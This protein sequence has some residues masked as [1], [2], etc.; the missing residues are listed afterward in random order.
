MF[1]GWWQPVWRNKR[2][3]R[4]QKENELFKTL[5]RKK[6]ERAEAEKE[7]RVQ[8]AMDYITPKGQTKENEIIDILRTYLPVVI[9]SKKD[10]AEEVQRIMY[11]VEPVS[12]DASSDSS[13]VIDATSD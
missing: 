13:S 3:E 11:A 1:G 10:I 2:K 7:A 6:K 5:N 4:K 9:P 8:L 12:D